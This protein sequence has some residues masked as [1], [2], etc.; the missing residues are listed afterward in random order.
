MKLLKEDY[1]QS[2]ELDTFISQLDRK[3]NQYFQVT[4]SNNNKKTEEY[5]SFESAAKEYYN[6]LLDEMQ[7]DSFYDGYNIK[8]EKVTLNKE[9]EE[10]NS[11]D[12]D[13]EE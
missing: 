12:I 1:G 4:I 6:K 11:Y 2:E 7:S 3:Y 8:L 5:F 9:Y 10:L 13:N